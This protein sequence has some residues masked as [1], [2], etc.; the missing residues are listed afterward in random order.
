[1]KTMSRA[2]CV[3][4]CETRLIDLWKKHGREA[5]HSVRHERYLECKDFCKRHGFNAVEF[6][7]M[8]KKAFAL[9]K[10]AYTE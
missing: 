8:W 1:M 9:A 6:Y 7:E 10:R 2:E 3:G 5:A 4:Y